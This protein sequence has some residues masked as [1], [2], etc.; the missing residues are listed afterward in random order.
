MSNSDTDTAAEPVAA[1]RLQR[2]PRARIDVRVVGTAPYIA[3][4]FDEKAREMMLAAQQTRTRTRKA[5]KDPVADFERSR[6]RLADGGDGAPAVAFKSAMVD[7]ARVFEGVK[8]TE[9]R[10]ALHVIGEGV[11][12]LVRLEADTPRMR[13]DTVRVGMGTADL[14]YRA[15]YWPW[16]AILTV[17]FIPTMLSAESVLAIVDAAGMGG[18]GEWR[19][20]KAKTGIY[21]TFAVED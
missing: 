14:R 4:R 7:S 2:I 21:G 3:H 6:Y 9:L 8:M 17:Q 1:I 18:I 13:E 11:D 20:S 5:A 19:P 16:A 10:P 15:E 12:Q